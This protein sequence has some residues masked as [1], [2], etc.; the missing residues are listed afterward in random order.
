MKRLVITSGGITALVW[1]A[2]LVAVMVVGWC[3]GFRR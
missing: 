1:L 2:M 3:G